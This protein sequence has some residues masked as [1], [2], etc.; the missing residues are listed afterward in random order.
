MPTYALVLIVLTSVIIALQ[1]TLV[2][3]QL[4]AL[5]RGPKNRKKS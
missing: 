1:S 5:R 2:T 3:L 4:I